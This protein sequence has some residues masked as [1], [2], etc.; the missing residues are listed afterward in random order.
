MLMVGLSV[1]IWNQIKKDLIEFYQTMKPQD[2][3]QY[4]V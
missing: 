2:M 3:A 4:C 1:E